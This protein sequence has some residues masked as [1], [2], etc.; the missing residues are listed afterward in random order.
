M[1]PNVARHVQSPLTVDDSSFFRPCT[2]PPVGS[3][4]GNG[5]FPWHMCI[6]KHDSPD[7]E[8]G[9]PEHFLSGKLNKVVPP[10]FCLLVSSIDICTID[11]CTI[12]ISTIDICTINP[13]SP[14]YEP[15]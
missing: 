10:K 9:L 11:I 14:T 6:L 1:S 13:E 12:D 15:T 7:S 5:P 3:K 4:H 2:V 8:V